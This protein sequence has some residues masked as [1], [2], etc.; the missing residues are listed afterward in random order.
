MS[1]LT[2]IKYYNATTKGKNEA[3]RDYLRYIRAGIP[4]R[5]RD[6]KMKHGRGVVLS[7]DKRYVDRVWDVDKE[8]E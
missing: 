2:A 6:I 1:K 4:C 8:R 5:I 7:A 3:G